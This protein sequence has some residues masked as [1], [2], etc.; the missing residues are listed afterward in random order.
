MMSSC[1]EKER[2][3]FSFK[4]L[5]DGLDKIPTMQGREMLMK[6]ERN[7]VMP[8]S[9]IWIK[10]DKTVMSYAHVLVYIGQKGETGDHEVV[11]VYKNLTSWLRMGI[12]LSTFQRINIKEVVNDEDE[13]EQCHKVVKVLYLVLFS[14]LWS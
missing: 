13:G 8:G 7:E 4:L 12:L 14:F 1:F 9:Q 10:R 2:K 3:E 5:K 6:I 11:H